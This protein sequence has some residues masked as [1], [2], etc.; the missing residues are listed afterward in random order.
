MPATSPAMAPAVP[1]AMLEVAG[2]EAG[3]GGPPVLRGVGLTVGAAE[4]VALLGANGAGK[5]TLLR[6][7][8]GL[9]RP[10]AGVVRV[11]GGDV[12][13]RP[14][15]EIAALGVSHVPEGR[16]IF[17]AMT[18]TENLLMGAYRRRGRPVFRIG[19][20]RRPAGP[21]AAP[22]AGPEVARGAAPGAG[23]GAATDAAPGAS[24]GAGLG[25]GRGASADA[26]PGAT[27]GAGLGAGLDEVFTLFPRLAQRRRQ[28]GG[29]LSG[30][31]QQMLAIGRALVA[32][33]RLMLL[34]EPAMGLAPLLAE[35][36]FDALGRIR[37]GGVAMLL[38]EQNARAALAVAAR[39]YVLERGRIVATDDAAALRGDERV[40]R[41][42]LGEDPDPVT[43]EAGIPPRQNVSRL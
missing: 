1:G 20:R 40:R 14:A 43:P 35:Q 2:L 27:R 33:P 8:S 4:I 21:G 28:A 36:I 11:A 32:R 23:H 22:R 18:V 31:E 7:V 34:D 37:D 29:S 16:R 26:G 41:A 13:G 3:Y 39:G 42:Y 6:T 38:V 30:G 5:S 10:S 17:P 25:A 24:H 12:A 15:H 9:L 19:R